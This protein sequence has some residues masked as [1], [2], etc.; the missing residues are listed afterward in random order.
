M[1]TYLLAGGGT[2][3][4]V[5]PLLALADEIHEKQPEDTVLILGTDEGLEGKL[6]PEKGYELLTIPKLP[7]PRKLNAYTFTFPFKF[8]AAVKEIKKIL[9][10]RKVDVVIGFGGYAAAPAY[11]AAKKTHPII[12]CEPNVLPGIANKIGS[13]WAKA[14]AV[15]Y[16]GTELPGASY[17]GVPLRKEVFDTRVTKSV[18]AKQFGLDPKKPVL[19][20]FGGSLGAKT[21]ND[22]IWESAADVLATGWQ[23]LQITGAKWSPPSPADA[24]HQVVEY[25]DK[26]GTAYSVA[27]LV[28]SRAGASSVAEITALELPAVYVPLPIGNGEQELNAE[29]SLKHGV[30]RMVANNLF[31]PDWVRSELVPLLKDPEK[32]AEMKN[33]YRDSGKA[34]DSTGAQNLL[35]LVNKATFAKR[36]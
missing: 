2:A 18:A 6:V 5:N 15:A 30:A 16:E 1:T 33:A 35:A 34:H 22:T 11:Q 13:K 36:S 12:V 3:G 27:D 21:I 23:I 31:T 8:R 19:L 24:G 17:V 20:V 26:M 9:K 10:N 25:V 4:H 28:L 14:V 32:I 7:F 29:W